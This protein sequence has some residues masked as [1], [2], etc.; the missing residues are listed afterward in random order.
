MAIGGGPLLL[1]EARL[2]DELLRL[3]EVA[4]PL[5]CYLAT[6]T[7]DDSTRIEQFYAAFSARGCETTHVELF[8]VSEDAAAQVAAADVVYVGGGNTVSL[9]AVWEAHGIGAA[10]RSVCERGGVLAGWSAG[11]CCWFDAFV[12]D[13]FGPLR[14]F[15]PGLGLAEGSFCPHFDGEPERRPAYERLVADG[16]PAGYAADDGA[17]V[18]LRDG[19]FVEAVAQRPGATAWRVEPGATEPLPTRL[20]A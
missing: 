12:T 16:F 5:V 9:L 6:A 19:T 11:G 10:C 3:S 14:G 7:G 2:E 20:L 18:V 8:G 15:A 17:A 4:R 1:A 13:S